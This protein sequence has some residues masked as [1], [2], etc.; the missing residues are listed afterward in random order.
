MHSTKRKYNKTQ[1]RVGLSG[2]QMQGTADHEKP[3]NKRNKTWDTMSANRGI[4]V[5]QLNEW[6]KKLHWLPAAHEKEQA[7]HFSLIKQTM[8]NVFF[9]VPTST[10]HVLY[11]SA[12]SKFSGEYII[13]MYYQ[14]LL[15][16]WFQ[17]LIFPPHKMLVTVI[18]LHNCGVFVIL[19]LNTRVLG[20]GEFTW[21]IYRTFLNHRFTYSKLSNLRV[22][23]SY[24]LINRGKTNL[25]F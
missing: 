13:Q 21:W 8:W 2:K 10:T 4:Y 25:L 19:K 6:R 11:T 5:Q 22:W 1:S 20:P 3:S 16:S 24:C 14:D 23:L 18:H 7:K 12:K 9:V 15:K 17:Q